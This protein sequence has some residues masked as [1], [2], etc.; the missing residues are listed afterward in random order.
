MKRGFLLKNPRP[1]KDELVKSEEL[2]D[3]FKCPGFLKKT[4]AV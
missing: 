3:K 4:G 1:L 2:A